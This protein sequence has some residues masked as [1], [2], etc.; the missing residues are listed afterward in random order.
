MRLSNRGKEKI[1][2]SIVHGIHKRDLP[3]A[4]SA[5][6]PDGWDFR[7]KEMQILKRE[8]QMLCDEEKEMAREK[9]ARQQLVIRVLGASTKIIDKWD[10]MAFL[11]DVT[12]ASKDVE[13]DET[14]K[15]LDE[16]KA[17]EAQLEM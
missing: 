1:M 15:I 9:T 5:T 17:R 11:R 4:K 7:N 13:I 2:S 6:K 8:L 16:T 3:P 10:E 14:N 12:I